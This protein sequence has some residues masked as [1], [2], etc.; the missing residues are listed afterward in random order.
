MKISAFIP[1]VSGIEA[2]LAMSSQCTLW[3]PSTL[4][5]ISLCSFNDSLPDNVSFVL[6]LAQRMLPSGSY[7]GADGSRHPHRHDRRNIHRCFY[8]RLVRRRTQLQPDAHQS[9]AVVHGKRWKC[10]SSLLRWVWELHHQP[11]W[12]V[13]HEQRPGTCSRLSFTVRVTKRAGRELGTLLLAALAGA[14]SLSLHQLQSQCKCGVMLFRCVSLCLSLF[15][16][17]FLCAGICFLS[18]SQQMRFSFV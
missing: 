4:L 5:F 14:E 15:Y 16:V 8:G 7:Q 17:L 12:A 2:C 18:D 1:F 6:S 10:C 3:F 11:G 13:G 9:P